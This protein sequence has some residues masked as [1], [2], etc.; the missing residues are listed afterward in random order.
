MAR[1][2]IVLPLTMRLAPL[3]KTLFDCLVNA[4]GLVII[5]IKAAVGQDRDEACEARHKEAEI[6]C[7]IGTV[8]NLT[9]FRGEHESSCKVS[10]DGGDEASAVEERDHIY[11]SV[12]CW[13]VWCCVVW[14]VVCCGVVLCFSQSNSLSLGEQRPTIPGK[15]VIICLVEVLGWVCASIFRIHLPQSRLYIPTRDMKNSECQMG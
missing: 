8:S 13:V 6:V 1:S 11:R 3:I 12:R 7:Q 2:D 10:Q 5:L 9:R 14:S 15:L 4:I